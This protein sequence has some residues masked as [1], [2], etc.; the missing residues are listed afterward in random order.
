[1]HVVQEP[2]AEQMGLAGGQ[3]AL[4]AQPTQTPAAEHMVRVGSASATHWAEVLQAVQAPAAQMGALAGQVAP[5]R[6]CTHLLV[7]VSQ[8][9]VAPEQVEL[10][11]HCTH[12]PAAEQATRAGSARAAHWAAAV[13]AVHLPAA[14]QI[15][16]TALQLAL[17]LHCGGASSTGEEV[18]GVVETSNVLPSRDAPASVGEIHS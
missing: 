15:G 11:M 9:G 16:A 5:V 13:Q 3:L 1:M 12:A 10:S 17:V 4:V 8:S 18:S 14:E 7:V 2:A 6:H